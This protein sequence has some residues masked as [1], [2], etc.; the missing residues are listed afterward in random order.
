M[1][2]RTQLVAGQRDGWFGWIRNVVIVGVILTE[3]AGAHLLLVNLDVPNIVVHGGTTA[4]AVVVGGSSLFVASSR[5]FESGSP[6]DSTDKSS[7]RRVS[8]V[9]VSVSVLTAV[10]ALL[11][12]VGGL[13]L[14]AVAKLGGPDPKTADGELLRN[15]LLGWVQRNRD[16]MRNDGRGEL[17]LRP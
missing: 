1:S 7:L 17:P 5:V 13:G 15:R 12:A 3:V 6:G 10:T 14:T 9:I 2:S 16:F 8:E 11:G 4:A